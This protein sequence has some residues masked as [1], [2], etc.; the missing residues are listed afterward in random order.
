MD[1]SCDDPNIATIKDQL[2]RLSGA[3]ITLG[4]V[5]DGEAL[6]IKS[7][8]I[9]AF[10][11]WWPKDDRHRVLRPSTVGPLSPAYFDSLH[12]T[13]CRCMTAP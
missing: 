8:I 5:R 11:L 6:T 13:P 2:A 7:A 10:S 1:K 3:H 9:S 12:A 4:V